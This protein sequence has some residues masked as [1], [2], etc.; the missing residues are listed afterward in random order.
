MSAVRQILLGAMISL[1]A[2]G[3]PMAACSGE[4]LTALVR[5]KLDALRVLPKDPHM[6]TP[7]D[8]VDVIER[9]NACERAEAD[10]GP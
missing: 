4:Q 9:V 3:V 8:A 1:V 7:Y 6:A 10:A 2:F 5:C